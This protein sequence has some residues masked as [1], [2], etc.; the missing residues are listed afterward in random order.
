MATVLIPLPAKDFDPTEAAVSWRVLSSAGHTVLFATPDGTRSFADD[1]MI[2]GEGLD[3]WGFVPGLRKLKV[4]GAILRANAE[5]RAA[6]AELERDAAF[7]APMR[8]DALGTV[9]FDGVLLPGGHRARGMRPYLE[10]DILQSLV[11]RAFEQNAKVAAV[12]HGVLLAARSISP[13]TSRSVLHGRRTTS[14]TWS[15]EHLAANLARVARFWDGNYYRT[16]EEKPGEPCGYMGVEAEVTRALA[17]PD[18]YVNVPKDAPD[19]VRK[20]D[21]RHRD[22]MDDARPAF[23]VR[24][25]PYLS[26]RWPGDVHTFAKTFAGML[27]E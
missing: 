20:T 24:D 16:Y 26:A 14:L 1:L 8:Y 21:G 13:R 25:G 27:A 3:P 10:S 5:G 2:S 18:D 15:Q 11:V 9:R 17:K 19:Y 23:V 22:T 7:L 12:C 6:Y 4:M